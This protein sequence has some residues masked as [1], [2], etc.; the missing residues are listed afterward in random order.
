MPLY[1]PVKLP[2]EHE[3]VEAGNAREILPGQ[4]R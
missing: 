2:E 1:T 3:P 4:L